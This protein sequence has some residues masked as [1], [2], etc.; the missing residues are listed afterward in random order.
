MKSFSRKNLVFIVLTVFFMFMNPVMA[1][2]YI[3]LGTGSFI[4]QA[5]LA[6]VLGAAYFIKISWGRIKNFFNRRL[7]T[8]NKNE[9]SKPQ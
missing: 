9:E 6:V 3:D 7:S 4:I 1:N 2:A 8:K 5:L